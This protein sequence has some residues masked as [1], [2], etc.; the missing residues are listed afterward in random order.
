M[1]WSDQD[2]W[3]DIHNL[4]VHL[5][6]YIA[7]TPNLKLYTWLYIYISICSR[8]ETYKVYDHKDIGYF[9]GEC[10]LKWDIYEPLK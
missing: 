7:G 2:Q 6:E 9:N 8:G 5:D 1:H 4:G 3:S 10:I